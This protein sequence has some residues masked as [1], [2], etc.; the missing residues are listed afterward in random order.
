MID[1]AIREEAELARETAPT[2]LAALNSIRSGFASLA[3]S[4]PKL[5]WKLM[6]GLLNGINTCVIVEL[7]HAPWIGF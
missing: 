7:Y 4:D 3:D 5:A 1:A 6:E 2:S